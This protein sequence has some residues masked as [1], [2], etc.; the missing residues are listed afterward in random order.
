V[1]LKPDWDYKAVSPKLHTINKKESHTW[2]LTHLISGGRGISEFKASLVYRVNFQDSQGYT[3][4][5]Y[6]ENK[7]SKR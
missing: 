2:L 3:E 7:I 6:L 1:N 4:K 5:P